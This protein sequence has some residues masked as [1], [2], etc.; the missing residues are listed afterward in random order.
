MWQFN[1]KEQ[2][3]E[4]PRMGVEQQTAIINKLW[5]QMSIFE[6]KLEGVQELSHVGYLAEKYF[7][8]R[9]HFRKVLILAGSGELYKYQ[10]F[11]GEE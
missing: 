7:M 3:S 4:E 9:E 6:Q 5:I 10:R 11:P 2:V 8:P 1:K